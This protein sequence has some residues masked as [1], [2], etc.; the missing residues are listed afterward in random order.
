M[1]K[2]ILKPYP[3][4]SPKSYSTLEKFNLLARY[5]CKKNY[6]IHDMCFFHVRNS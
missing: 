4:P 6:L 5:K 2:E 3:N 1:K